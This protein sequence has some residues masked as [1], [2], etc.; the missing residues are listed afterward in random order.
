MLLL[1]FCWIVSWC[2]ANYGL[3]ST[4]FPFLSDLPISELL[5]ALAH[6]ASDILFAIRKDPFASSFLQ[7]YSAMEL[8]GP[9]GC[10]NFTD[11][12]H[13]TVGEEKRIGSRKG[14]TG[15]IDKH[16]PNLN[17]EAQPSTLK[18]SPCCWIGLIPADF[19]ITRTYLSQQIIHW[20]I[21]P[22]GYILKPCHGLWDHFKIRDVTRPRS[23]LRHLVLWKTLGGGLYNFIWLPFQG[24]P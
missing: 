14:C 16:S 23:A 17:P 12:L 24:L 3:Q 9:Q 21:P 22:C 5:K 19:L 8:L 7:W 13:P 11:M 2:S 10:S 1:S 4:L 6:T 20:S 15:R 18:F